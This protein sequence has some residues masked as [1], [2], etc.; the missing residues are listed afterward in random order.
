MTVATHATKAAC[1]E[2]AETIA[3]RARRSRARAAIPSAGAIAAADA[4]AVDN[5]GPDTQAGAWA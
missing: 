3:A 5:V 4:I 2:K 1:A